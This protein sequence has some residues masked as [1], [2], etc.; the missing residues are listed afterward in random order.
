MADELNP[1]K[2]RISPIEAMNKARAA[3]VVASR[4]TR[5]QP[6]APPAGKPIPPAPKPPN[7]QAPSAQMHTATD[8][9]RLV[10]QIGA[11]H[12][13]P[14]DI[15]AK[16]LGIRVDT[17]RA[18]YQEELNT[19]P[20]VIKMR[21]EMQVVRRALRGSD[22]MTRLWLERWG[23]EQWKPVEKRIHSGTLNFNGSTDELNRAIEEL[24]RAE[25]VGDAGRTRATLLPN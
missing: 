10:V 23:G 3:K 5:I 19:G 17:L 7:K 2:P 16:Q 15:L 24:E 4:A 25:S 18:N 6:P 8:A 21:L 12:G 20:A 14:V 9:T 22:S 13:T 1:R 11:A